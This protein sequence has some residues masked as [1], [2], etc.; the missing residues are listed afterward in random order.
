MRGLVLAAGWGRR[1]GAVAAGRPKALL[2]VAGR[3]PADFVVEALEG[4]PDL[5]GI[6][7]L[8]HEAFR[9]AFERWSRSR[10]PGV[11][12]RVWSNGTRTPAEQRGAVRDLALLLELA[13]PAGPL[14]VLGADMVFDADLGPL[15]RE[16]RAGPALA[17]HDV[18]SP[19]RVRLLASVAL[20]AAGR[21]VRFVEKDPEPAT[22]L[23]APA[24]YGLPDAGAGEVQRYL[25]EGGAPDNLGHWIAWL[26]ARRPV[27][28]VRLAGRWI[29]VGTP[30]EYARARDWF[31]A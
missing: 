28:G 20:D 8:T 3:T 27:R 12:L 16:A 4:L 22:T 26:V 19:E 15:A 25:E 29:D 9:P 14:L 10:A 23:A 1:L 24:L 7:L 13:Q 6:D 31:G 11:P 17:V 21:V 5:E 18:G 30:E 2:P